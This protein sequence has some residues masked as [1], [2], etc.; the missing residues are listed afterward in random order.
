MREG[1][2]PA[3][4]LC[5]FTACLT[6]NPKALGLGPYA[7]VSVLTQGK[8]ANE[9]KLLDQHASCHSNKALE[10]QFVMSLILIS[11]NA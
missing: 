4:V 7:A 10:V 1:K 11:Y 5:L 2:K 8:D 9:L 3:R 6:T